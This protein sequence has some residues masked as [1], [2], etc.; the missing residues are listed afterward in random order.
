VTV[1]VQVRGRPPIVLEHLVIDLNGT[2]TDRGQLIAGVREAV[3]GLRDA[4]SIHLA[5]ADT[6]GSG[7]RVADELG[8]G[9]QRIVAG[10]EKEA[11]VAR[12]GAD[13]TVAVGN[14]VND[15]PMLRAARLGIAVLG[16]EGTS[17]AALAAADLVT[18]SIAAAL[19]LLGDPPALTATLR[20]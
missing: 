17:T 19:A 20:P 14:G 8:V 10:E 18:S 15:V 5:T 9:L 13:R 7:R 4:L 12:L 11:L 2:L 6:F 3:R 1:E 16:P